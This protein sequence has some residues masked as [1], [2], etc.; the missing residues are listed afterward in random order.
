MTSI[1]F[2]ISVPES[3]TTPSIVTTVAPTTIEPSSDTGGI[4]T[5]E[6]DNEEDADREGEEDDEDK[7]EQENEEEEEQEE[8]E[9]EECIDEKL[10][11]RCKKWKADGCVMLTTSSVLR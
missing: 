9:E 6:D 2:S 5:H 3:T 4:E 11:S 8:E 1:C 7:D 10:T